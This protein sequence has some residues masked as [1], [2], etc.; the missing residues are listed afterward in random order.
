[1][2]RAIAKHVGTWIPCCVLHTRYLLVYIL[3]HPPRVGCR[4]GPPSVL[5]GKWHATERHIG[6]TLLAAGAGRVQSTH[7]ACLPI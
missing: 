4:A 5:R 3:H 2:Q 7:K 6:G 1:M